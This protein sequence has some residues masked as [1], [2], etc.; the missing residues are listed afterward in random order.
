MNR[1][2]PLITRSS[3][4]AVAM[5]SW[6]AEP[7]SEPS[8]DLLDDLKLFALGWLGGLVFFGTLLA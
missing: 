6:I 1:L 3:A 2:S 5:D 8:T 4:R 7:A